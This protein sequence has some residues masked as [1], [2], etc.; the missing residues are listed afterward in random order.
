MQRP[1]QDISALGWK[2]LWPWIACAALLFLSAATD[3]AT[4]AY[5]QMFSCPKVSQ[6]TL[7]PRPRL[8]A[9]LMRSYLEYEA[10]TP[11]ESQSKI[12]FGGTVH[13]TADRTGREAPEQGVLILHSLKN[14]DGTTNTSA[15]AIASVLGKEIAERDYQRSV[16]IITLA[17][18]RFAIDPSLFSPWK[19]VRAV[20]WLGRLTEFTDAPESQQ[21]PRLTRHLY[22]TTGNFVAFVGSEKAKGLCDVA[23]SYFRRYSKLPSRCFKP[24]PLGLAALTP[25]DLGYP[26]MAVPYTL[27]TDT[28]RFRR[29][30]NK[31]D[32][33]ALEQIYLGVLK[34]VEGFATDSSPSLPLPDWGTQTARSLGR[35][36]ASEVF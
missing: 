23:S 5:Q 20:L 18:A 9:A 6:G 27:I 33:G 16:R 4:H 35:D 11:L 15:L 2:N 12:G 13:F 17:D 36:S 28:E 26:K 19:A 24:L 3:L 1:L 31:L 30:T 8:A 21:L 10:L 34:A 7:L 25:Q 14:T 29:S 22:P 32:L